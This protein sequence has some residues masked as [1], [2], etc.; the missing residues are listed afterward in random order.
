[1]LDTVAAVLGTAL[2]L[3][4]LVLATIGLYG[5]LRRQ[6]IFE[7]LHAAG[8]V[9]GPGVIL[10]LLASLA[11][12]RAET[13]TSALLV[14]VFVLVTASLSTHAI[15]L[16]AWRRRHDI[17]TPS[18]SVPGAAGSETAAVGRARPGPTHVLLAH[19]GSR[20]AEIAVAFVA[21][22]S[23]P[24]GCV[25]RL[26][27]VV[28]GDLPLPAANE[29]ARDGDD[30]D[31]VDL[32]A[33]LE[34][35]AADLRRPGLTVEAVVRRGGAAAAIVDEATAFD[36][37]LVV[38]G[39]RGLGRVRS[40][41]VG[42][43][44]GEV[45]DG[46]PC[47][48][49]VAR[50]TT[51]QTVLHAT[52]GSASSEAATDV[53]ARWP[54]FEGPRIQVLSVGAVTPTATPD[55]TPLDPAERAAG[56]LQAAGRTAVADVRTGDAAGTILALAEA[57]AADLIVVGSRGNTGLRRAV[58]GSVARDVLARAPTSVLVVRAPTR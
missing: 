44:A 37:E 29:T 35:A 20:D 19:D 8:L 21:G 24:A 26:I 5:L 47:P 51:L 53:L 54:V 55:G 11:T 10:I 18:K 41:L 38:M 6:D 32:A 14:V 39:S 4:G 36:A 30:H 7:Q 42:S 25:I 28:E 15:A 40:L 9:T 48:V 12:G 27:A 1:M 13:I 16:A 58:L 56:R 50:S 34:T 49:L 52:D 22:R 2:L 23:W 33:V 17:G 46:A 57:S 43:V 31:P 45:V 3:L